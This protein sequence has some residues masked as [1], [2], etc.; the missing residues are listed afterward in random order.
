MVSILYNIQ[1][2]Y[3][4]IDSNILMMYNRIGFILYF[5]GPSRVIDI[6]MSH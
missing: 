5:Y 4:T 1:Y 2:T 3:N 6:L